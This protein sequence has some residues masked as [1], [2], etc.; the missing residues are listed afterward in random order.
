MHAH[1]WN[2]G[3]EGRAW[4]G[5]EATERHDV[6]PARIEMIGGKTLWSEEERLVLLVA[7]LENVGAS[8]LWKLA[9]LR[10]GVPPS[11]DSVNDKPPAWLRTDTSIGLAID[12]LCVDARSEVARCHFAV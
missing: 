6:L 12:G 5:P 8:K 1:N 4:V 2:I 3:L 7:L 10:S 9:T 11:L